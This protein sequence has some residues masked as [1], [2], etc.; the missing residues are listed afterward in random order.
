MSDASEADRQEQDLAVEEVVE[1]RL[2][3]LDELD[4]EAPPADAIEQALPADLDPE[5]RR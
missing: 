5:D 4:L 2:P 1:V 3:H